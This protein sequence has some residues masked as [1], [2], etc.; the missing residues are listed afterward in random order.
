MNRRLHQRSAGHRG[1]KFQCAQQSLVAQHGSGLA[2]LA[3]EPTITPMI[4]AIDALIIQ[5]RPIRGVKSF[6]LTAH[7]EVR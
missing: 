3:S 2:V 4:V 1:G 7:G 6:F 5:S